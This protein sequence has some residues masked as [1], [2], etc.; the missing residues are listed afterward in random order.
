[1]NIFIKIVESLNLSEKFCMVL[2]QRASKLS[3]IGTYLEEDKDDI[4][5]L[6]FYVTNEYKILNSWM[7]YVVSIKSLID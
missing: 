4:R 5:L 1:M 7:L 3:F 6:S 2:E